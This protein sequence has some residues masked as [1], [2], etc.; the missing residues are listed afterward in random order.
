LGEP[1]PGPPLGRSDRAGRPTLFRGPGRSHFPCT[2]L[3]R[4]C[5]P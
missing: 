3:F 1:P 4:I 2:A 5:S